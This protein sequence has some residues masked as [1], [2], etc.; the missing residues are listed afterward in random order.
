MWFVD[1][2][3][4]SDDTAIWNMVVWDE[5]CNI[6]SQKSFHDKNKFSWS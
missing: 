2:V 6:I 3:K 4:Q 1:I 5:E